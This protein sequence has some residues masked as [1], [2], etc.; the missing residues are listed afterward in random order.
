MHL[1]FISATGAPVVIT[2]YRSITHPF[3][4]TPE[5]IPFFALKSKKSGSVK[6]IK[7]YKHRK[8]FEQ[9]EQ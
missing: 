6:A 7:K 1:S 8:Q 4:S 5:S 3:H 9:Y 2:N